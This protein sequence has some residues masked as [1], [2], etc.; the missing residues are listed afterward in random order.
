MSYNLF[1]RMADKIPEA[2]VGSARVEH[3]I[4][5]EAN[6]QLAALRALINSRYSEMVSPGT[7]AKLA[8]GGHTMMTDTDM[9]HKTN[10][11]LIRHAKGHVLVGGLGL[12]MI[13]FGLLA[14]KPPIRSLLVL[15]KNLDVIRLIRPHL[16]EDARFMVARADVFFWEQQ[17]GWPTKFDT[18]YF[19]IWP[20]IQDHNLP[21][22][23]R[24][25][26]RAKSWLARG[27]WLGDWDTEYRRLANITHPRT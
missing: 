19:D 13:V 16:P 24:L 11:P 7:Y 26:I 17:A 10:S 14:K 25:R 6:A 4:V 5:T 23:K 3:F 18:I 8:V 12:G 1:P 2:A 21:E 22:V 20:S 9:E 27:G 15:E